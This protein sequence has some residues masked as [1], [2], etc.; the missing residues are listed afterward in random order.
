MPDVPYSAWNVESSNSTCGYTD[1]VCLSLAGHGLYGPSSLF[2][3]EVGSQH[4][5]KASCPRLF[6]FSPQ[7]EPC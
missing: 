3:D 4:A 5:V 1:K 7:M 6:D 2:M